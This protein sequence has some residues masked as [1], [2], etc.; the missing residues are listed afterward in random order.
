V[1]GGETL[2]EKGHVMD[3]FD[4]SGLTLCFLAHN[5]LNKAS[6]ILGECELLRDHKVP[7]QGAER[8]HVIQLAAEAMI[9]SIR[10]YE[11][12]MR[13]VTGQTNKTGVKDIAH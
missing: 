11:C 6:V 7:P 13:R 12:Q 3:E 2:W 4:P 8:L 9:Q 1:S 10:T 5:L